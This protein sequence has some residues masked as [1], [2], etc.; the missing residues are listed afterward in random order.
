M[1]IVI[2]NPINQ[3][4][5]FSKYMENNFNEI[6]KIA[7]DSLEIC[8]KLFNDKKYEEALKQYN[9]A[10]YN[11]SKLIAPNNFHDHSRAYCSG[12]IAHAI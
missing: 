5:I 3:I 1:I 10:L 12:K 7:H 6:S 11:F 4:N 2:I 8:D 9:T